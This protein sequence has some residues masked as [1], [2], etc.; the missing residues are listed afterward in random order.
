MTTEEIN[1]TVK[2]YMRGQPPT[3]LGEEVDAFRRQLAKDVAKA[4]A[5]GW[6]IEIPFE[7][8]VGE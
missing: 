1:I 4:K 6:V 2:E 7:I 8:G 5:N 3:I